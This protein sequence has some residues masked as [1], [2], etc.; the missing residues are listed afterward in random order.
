V[1]LRP[2]RTASRA[3]EGVRVKLYQPS[4]RKIRPM[5]EREMH[6]IYALAPI[7]FAPRGGPVGIE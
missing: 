1:V 7:F 4:E 3:A 5:P 6:F 2:S